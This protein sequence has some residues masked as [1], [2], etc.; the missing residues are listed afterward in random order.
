MIRNPAVLL[1]GA[2]LLLATSCGG[3]TES[4]AVGA[5]D[6]TVA[7]T[8]EPTAA[9]DAVTTTPV[10]TPTESDPVATDP[11]PAAS[12]PLTTD[13]A[14]PATTVAPPPASGLTP[15]DLVLRPDGIGPFTFGAVDAST[16]AA[17]VEPVL[18][19][20]TQFT[21]ETY[22]VDAEFYY[23]N[24]DDESGFTFPFGETVCFSNALCAFFGGDAAASATFVGYIQDETADALAT[25]SGV[26]S[27]ARWADHEAAIQMSDGGCFSTG[28]GVAD[29]VGIVALSLGE[30]FEFYDA[31]EET[32]VQQTPPPDDVIVISLNAGEQPF[33]LYADC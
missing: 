9:T 26:T 27:G 33:F 6:A 17:A 4:G 11:E 7:P 1:V 14:T 16:F 5:T 2:T 15:A 25:A 3:S 10:F 28:Y 8:S 18:G 21:S 31:E 23:E 20:P 12:A 13:A 22:P 24:V 32:Y 29:G 30:P 19:A